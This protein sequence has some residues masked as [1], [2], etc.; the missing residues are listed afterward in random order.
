MGN[1]IIALVLFAVNPNIGFGT[2]QILGEHLL[3]PSLFTMRI[4]IGK[5]FVIAPEVN[6][7]YSSQEEEIDSTKGS[8]LTLG[9]EANF[10]YALLKRKKTGFYGIFGGGGE[11][12]KRISEWYE[13]EWGEPDSL[14]EVKRTT[15]THS[16]GLNL[17]LGIERFLT[18]NLS[19]CVSSL[20]NVTMQDEKAE[21]E[22]KGEKEITYRN[23]GYSFDFQNL[24]CCVYLIWYI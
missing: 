7:N 22:E 18:D 3:M 16:Y 9:V 5:S 4:G 2:G 1:L 17:G 19:V 20:S 8:D 6:V 15:T 14:Y 10:H 13:H 24:K 11:F 23:S 21:K 12:S